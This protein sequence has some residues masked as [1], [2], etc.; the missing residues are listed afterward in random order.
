M[1]MMSRLGSTEVG[2][3][4]FDGPVGSIIQKGRVNGR[5]FLVWIGSWSVILWLTSV[6][7]RLMLTLVKISCFHYIINV[8]MQG[9]A[10]KLKYFEMS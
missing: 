4:Q 2:S 9:S 8:I 6:G 3:G 1:M 7:W 5:F 10:K